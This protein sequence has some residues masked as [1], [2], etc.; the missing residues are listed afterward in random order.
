MKTI[1]RFEQARQQNVNLKEVGINPTFYWAYRATQ[2]TNNDTIDLH[3]V[4]WETDV[5]PI[6]EH[7]K[8]FGISE[9]TIS[10]NVSGAIQLLALFMHEGCT[11]AGMRQVKTEHIDWKTKENEVLDAIVIQMPQDYILGFY[12]YEGSDNLYRITENTDKEWLKDEPDVKFL[13]K[14]WLPTKKENIYKTSG[15]VIPADFVKIEEF[16]KVNIP[17]YKIYGDIGEFLEIKSNK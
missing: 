14:E 2:H 12:K 9:I 13:W 7:C 5:K 6:V 3:E 17:N 1:E 4:I 16:K 8:E 10:S 15:N 11:I